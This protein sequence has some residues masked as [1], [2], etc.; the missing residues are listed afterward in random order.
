MSKVI[1]SMGGDDA[2]IRRLDAS[3]LP[4]LGADRGENNNAGTAIYNPGNE[5]SFLIPF[6]YNYVPGYHWKTANQTRAIV[7]EFCTY[8]AH[9][10]GID[11][12]YTDR[13][14]TDNDGRSGYPGNTDAGAI[15]SWLVFN[16]I[17]FYPV[18]GQP[19]YLLGAPRFPELRVTLLSGTPFENVLTIR[20]DNLSASSYYPQSVTLDGQALDR[21]WLSHVELATASELVFQMGSEPAQWDTGSRPWSLSGWE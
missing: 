15:P 14:C 6:L 18:V 5:P 12:V 8:I 9:S 2:F 11:S 13:T 7:D 19:L 10:S 16:L 20:A 17:G 3:F 21:S 1:E 4:G